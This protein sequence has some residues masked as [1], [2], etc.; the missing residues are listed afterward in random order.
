MNSQGNWLISIYCRCYSAYRYNIWL[1][2]EGHVCIETHGDL[3]PCAALRK[4]H[5]HAHISHAKDSSVR[6][7]GTVLL[8]DV[9]VQS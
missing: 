7:K 1:D 5:K 8:K 2:A 6:L 3:S 9:E 4:V